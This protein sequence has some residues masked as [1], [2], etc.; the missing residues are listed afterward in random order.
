MAFSETATIAQDMDALLQ[1]TEP[2]ERLRRE[3]DAKIASGAWS[4]NMRLPTERA[5]SDAFGIGRSRVRRIL[6]EFER[7]G[8]IVRTVGRG[9]FVAGSA[10]PTAGIAHDI[11]EVSPE[12]LM[13]ARL[14]IE[15]QIVA[16]AVRRATLSE[17]SNLRDLVSKGRDCNSMVEFEAIDHS[18]HDAL[19]AAAK[20]SYLSG[21][22]RRMQAVRR[23]PAW[24]A[25]RRKGLNEDRR[26]SY[27][28][29]HEAIMDALEAR[30]HDTAER[31]MREHLEDVRAN[32]WL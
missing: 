22:I 28:R 1:R 15:P 25:L 26:R 18:F 13:E 11:E 27:Q 19:T 10:D 20:N 9:T 8:R 4:R 31:L 29:Q 21:I 7:A 3:I 2:E 6:E 12:D 16:L 23:S 14:L 32:I 5:L 17:L 30:D 24:G